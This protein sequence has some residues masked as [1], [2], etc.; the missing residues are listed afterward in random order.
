MNRRPLIRHYE[1]GIGNVLMA[2]VAVVVII[3]VAFTVLGYASEDEYVSEL[4]LTLYRRSS[5]QDYYRAD[6]DMDVEDTSF[7]NNWYSASV[8]DPGF[9]DGD[10]DLKVRISY[11]WYSENGDKET[12]VL[13]ERAFKDVGVHE[14]PDNQEISYIIEFQNLKRPAEHQ[15]EENAVLWA[16]VYWDGAL[17]GQK[18][19]VVN[20]ALLEVREG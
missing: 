4:E 2:I 10:H 3:V 12:G 17:I 14:D 20:Y 19:F 11:E 18:R 5:T 6:I 8:S 1:Q 9:P 13:T 7:L 15:D 16:Y